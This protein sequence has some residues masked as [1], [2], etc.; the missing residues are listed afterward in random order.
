VG[1]PIVGGK[2]TDRA[3]LAEGAK[4]GEGAKRVEAGKVSLGL[5]GGCPPPGSGGLV[6]RI[7]LVRLLDEL[8]QFPE[9]LPARSYGIGRLWHLSV[10][11]VYA[12]LGEKVDEP[13]LAGRASALGCLR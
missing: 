12:G 10:A 1:K 7:R 2:L 5:G 9:H 4:L 3:R 11:G 6:L 13:L 8:T